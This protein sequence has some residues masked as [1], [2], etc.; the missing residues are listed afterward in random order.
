MKKQLITL[1]VI[2]LPIM[3]SAY[4]T[5]IDGIYYNVN[6]SEMTAE[7]TYGNWNYWKTTDGEGRYSGVIEIPESII[8][9]ESVY[10][11]TKIGYCA[12][13]GCSG[14]TSIII[15]N[16]V[17]CL[18]N[19]AFENCV[20]LASVT[21]PNSII[22]IGSTVFDGSLWYDNLPDGLIYIGK[23]A[24]KYKGTMP[25]NTKIEI[26]EGIVKVQNNAFSGF[27]NLTSVSFPNSLLSIG[28]AAFSGCSGLISITLH[29]G[30]TFIDEYAFEGCTGLTSISIPQSVTSIGYCAFSGCKSLSSVTLP[31]D[32]VSV[33]GY[34]FN[35][36][37]WYNNQPDGLIYIGKVV[38]KY[39]GE[40]ANT[41]SIKEGTIS[42]SSMAFYDCSNL[43]SVSFPST[44]TSIGYQAFNGCN[45]LSSLTIPE[46]V[47]VIGQEC[48]YNC[49]KLS[50]VTILAPFL[51]EYGANAF[52]NNAD[53]RIIYVPLAGVSTYKSEWSRYARAIYYIGDNNGSCGD[54][55]T[56]SFEESTGLLY[57]SGTGAMADFGFYDQ[58]PWKSFSSSIKT[59]IIETGITSIGDNAFLDCSSIKEITIPISVGKVS[60]SSLLGTAW[61]D[62][63]PDG[64]I[65]AG[66]VAYRYKG[67][68]PEN[69]E[70]II[71]EGT[72]SI[73][74]NAF[75]DC[76][77]LTTI[78]IPQSVESIGEWAF[79]G[80]SDLTS[81]NIPL[82]ITTIGNYTFFL[83]SSLRSVI[84]PDKVTSIGS[85]AFAYC[86]GLSSIIIPNGVTF[87]GGDAFGGCSSLTSI[88]IPNSVTSIGRN[89]FSNCTSLS[90]ITIPNSVTFLDNR[91]FQG[92]SGLTSV[93]IPNSVLSIGSEAFSG[94][95]ALTSIKIPSSVTSISG[96]A[97]A[98]CIGLTTMKIPENLTNIESRLFAGCTS[99][100]SVTIPLSV[101]YIARD[102][103]SGCSSL[104]SIELPSNLDYIGNYA[105]HNCSSLTSI[106]I[107]SSV[108]TIGNDVFNGCSSLNS[109]VVDKSNTIYDSRDNCNAIIETSTNNLIV[110]CN[111][112]VIPN[113]VSSI[114][115][116]AFYNCIGL[117]SVT[118]PQSV[119]NIDDNAFY[120]CTGLTS[121]SVDE[122]NTKYDSRDN[123]N[124]IIET[125]TNRLIVACNNSIIPK[126][127]TSFSQ[128]ALK[129]CVSLRLP[130][131]METISSNLLY[132]CNKL[133][134]LW[135][136]AS[137]TKIEESAF[138]TCSSLK[139]VILEDGTEA[140]TLA[141]SYPAYYSKPQ[142]FSTCPLDSV[143]IGRDVKYVF[144]VQGGT[145]SYSPFREKETLRKVVFG[146]NVTTIPNAMFDGCSNLISV[147][148]PEEMDSIGYS[149]FK[150]CE[151]LSSFTLPH[152]IRT[153]SSSTFN[154]CKSLTSINIP[155]TV[156]SIEEQAFY[157]C[158]GLTSLIIPNNVKY[159]GKLAFGICT[160]L[161]DLVF[162]DGETSLTIR[163]ESYASAF[164]QCPIGNVY[165]GRNIINNSYNYIYSSLGSISTPFNLTISKYVTELEGGTFA[166]CEKIKTL[167]FEEGSDTLTFINDH[168]A[169][170]A[171]MPFANTPID[172]IYMGRIIVGKDIYY[173]NNTII[174]FANV[175][176]SF[177]M[178]VGD[179]ITEIGDRA[180][181]GWMVSSLIIPDKVMKI[182]VDAFSS[183]TSLSSV[184]IEN[185]NTTL[186][187]MEGSG[188]SGCQLQNL[189][190]GR[191]LTYDSWKSPFRFNKEAL[192]SLTIGEQVTEIGDCQFVGLKS[193]KALEFPNSI[194]K[195][196]VQAFYGCE[197]LTSVSIPNS[198]MEIGEDAFGLTRG[199]TSF[200]IEDGTESLSI[201][202]NFLNSPLN[203]VYLGRNL[204]YPEGNSPFSMLESLKLLKIGNE[205]NNIN[206]GAFAGC[207]NLKD[208]V[209]YA[210]NVPTT[211]KNVFTESYLYDATLHV[212][213]YTYDD[214]SKIY[215]WRMFKNFML[216]DPD[217]N[218]ILI[219]S[220]I[221]DA[222]GDGV[223]DVGDV[224]TMIDFILGKP[225]I[226]FV[227]LSADLNGDGEV[228]IF[229]VMKAVNLVASQKYSAREYAR[230]TRGSIEHAIVKTA[231]DGITFGI[232]DASRFTAFQFDVEVA[233]GVE[234][235]DAHLT[236][237]NDNH[238]LRFIKNGENSYRVV[239][240]S[241]N[242][243]TL[244]ANGNELVCLSLSKACDVHI[245][246]NIFVTPQETKVYFTSGGADVTGVGI[247]ENEK[248]EEIYDLSGRKVDTVRNSLPKGIYIINNK[249]VV[250]K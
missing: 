43:V 29:E 89:A 85:D 132:D 195:I 128:N 78:A 50:L 114:G 202:N 136:P 170:N 138:N 209:S 90:S 201:N 174:P 117:S 8:Y 108:N 172:S 111:K 236:V 15:P 127:I 197:G 247:I 158:E 153:I 166:N 79:Y 92:C 161:S 35:E 65:Y 30:V 86:D 248:V 143:Y 238:T 133:V 214:Y 27:K 21:I 207:Q 137:V 203:E 140:I 165:L 14:L 204:V 249:K 18:D 36:T 147:V 206:D 113:S 149:A 142:W 150:G 56:Y 80:C 159:I 99:L 190:L 51:T 145:Y 19:N 96:S 139:T 41:I 129:N 104:A 120:D 5:E 148:T 124:A 233:D 62:N 48:F 146:D 24:Y 91:I 45:S 1:I 200:T 55:V 10:N 101:T 126:G 131:G 37:P 123:C 213:D 186:D 20:G 179:N 12:F 68:M 115:Y 250:I 73:T 112:T 219:A 52:D 216:I 70:I 39:K 38:Y 157:Y 224:V 122:N 88:E 13:C 102:A 218:E 164:S 116:Y 9:N 154:N 242:N 246:N 229:D 244:K 221:G 144:T 239:C 141:V 243:S 63:Q 185:G 182:G 189:Y 187:F 225:T 2:L 226:N 188:F 46:G 199:L 64:L 119:T 105:F 34:A 17:T 107:P 31:D 57:I 173:P 66:K 151:S 130:D 54:D 178:R 109:I 11:V 184:S 33:G 163:E 32:I 6:S 175:G 168:N 230:A 156:K 59:V 171:I 237:D 28:S 44:I 81:V 183:C 215:P 94:C 74:A 72:P 100:A 235:T 232:N 53:D 222:D 181:S 245:D 110:G 155:E 76:K 75:K 69:T 22:S 95:K 93:E 208:V 134:T 205:V 217:G 169:Y 198:V 25:E 177:V 42:I 87:I 97:F 135:I 61:Y 60:S 212:L 241:M 125:A 162:Q 160:N 227:L 234:L 240:V 211:G 193:L 191:N 47:K 121:I 223:I 180:F 7:V 3:A 23:I 103:F 82:N 228:D 98:D 196:G 49:R 176:S 192:S 16:S 26:K 58:T 118:I 4:D 77:G 83:C 84:I 71:K 220:S 210:V 40:S 152:G 106:I 167:K 67:E 194:K 231:A